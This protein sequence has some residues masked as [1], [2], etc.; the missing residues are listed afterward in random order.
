VGSKVNLDVN[1]GKVFALHA[2]FVMDANGPKNF[3]TRLC[4]SS[5]RQ[6]FTEMLHV[7]ILTFFLKAIWLHTAI[8][9]VVVSRKHCLLAYSTPQN[10]AVNFEL[11][12]TVWVNPPLGTWHFFNFF[13]KTLSI[14]IRFFIHLLNVPIFARLQVFIQLSP[15]LTKLCHIKRDYPVHII[16]STWPK[17]ARSDVCVSRW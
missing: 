7:T 2:T 5:F 6:N 11:I 15:I 13:H 12:H 17:R 16:C 4:K 14:C 10:K 1:A 8:L 9:S 3:L